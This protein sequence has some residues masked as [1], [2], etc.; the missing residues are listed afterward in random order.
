[1]VRVRR[2]TIEVFPLGLA[3]EGQL[4]L[5]RD[6]VL[7][8]IHYQVQVVHHTASVGGEAKATTST[9]GVS[10]EGRRMGDI[11]AGFL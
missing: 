1:M 8:L 11:C 10:S 3:L 5:G 4:E 7:H 2:E 9:E 6:P